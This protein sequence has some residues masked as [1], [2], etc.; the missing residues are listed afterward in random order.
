MLGKGDLVPSNGR[1]IDTN[2]MDLWV[3]RT[4]AFPYGPGAP[5]QHPQGQN[6][7]EVFK[8]LW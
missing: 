5:C 4:L 7:A 1:G 6:V 3:K 8:T 2:D